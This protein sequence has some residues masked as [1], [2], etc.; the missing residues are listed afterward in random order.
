MALTLIN[1]AADMHS[2]TLSALLIS[3]LAVSACA[4]PEPTGPEVSRG[5]SDTA[6]SERDAAC[7]LEAVYF[8]AQ[9]NHMDGGKAVA[10]VILNR[11]KDPRFPNSVCGVVADGQAQGRCQFSYR[12]DRRADD[13]RDQ[14]KLAGA[15][16]VVAQVAQAPEEDV[17]DGALFFHASWMKPGWF[18]KL[19]RTVVLGNQ[20]FYRG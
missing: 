9:A 12:C 14:V 16:K 17:T 11:A 1:F 13:F 7:L 15:K 20:I 5:G 19:R 2:K 18:A 6:I 4:T 10:H 8:E 3:A